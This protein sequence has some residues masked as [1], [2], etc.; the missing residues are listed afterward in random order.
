MYYIV[1][2]GNPGEEY[3]NTRHNAGRT[4]L[5]LLQNKFELDDFV[6]DQKNNALTSE[7]KIGKEKV[8]LIQ[9]EGFM[10]N[11]GKSLKFIKTKKEASRVIVIYDDLDLPL[12]R[13]KMSFNRGTGGHKGVESVAK[14]LKTLEFIRVR[15][16]VSPQTPTGKTKKPSG[17]DRV[18]K[19]ILGKF[20]DEELKELKKVAKQVG[21]VLTILFTEKKQAL[22]KATAVANQS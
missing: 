21:E 11:S 5:E 10:N 7:G 4:I 14:Q 22:E 15:I 18:I 20:K 17:E 9:P 3:I 16:G 6:L 19:F 13:I 1:G 2:L 8:C 12:G